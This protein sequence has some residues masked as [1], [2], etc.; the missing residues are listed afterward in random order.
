MPRVWLIAMKKKNIIFNNRN[1][2]ETLREQVKNLTVWVNE[3][4]PS[5]EANERNAK[6]NFDKLKN[7]SKNTSKNMMDVAGILG[8]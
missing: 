2:V 7:N 1:T 6:I 4:M 8:I 5:I 3:I